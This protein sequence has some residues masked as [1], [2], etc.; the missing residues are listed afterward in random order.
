MPRAKPSR[1]AA[2]AA[3]LPFFLPAALCLLAAAFLTHPAA[4]LLLL[5]ANSLT[6]AAVCH[7]LGFALEDS[8]ARTVLRRGAAHLVMLA[9]YT[10]AVMLLLGWPLGWLLHGGSLAATMCLSAAVVAAL[11]LLWRVWPAFGLALVW[12]DAYPDEEE[13]SWILTAVS[14]SVTFARHVYA[15][16]TLTNHPGFVCTFTVPRAD[17]RLLLLPIDSG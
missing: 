11:L 1:L 3:S 17:A 12:D 15:D 2:F 4:L 5:A 8:F 14:R 9:S 16:D 6:L 13:G 10:A 7:G